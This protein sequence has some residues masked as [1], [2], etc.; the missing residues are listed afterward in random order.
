MDIPKFERTVR[1][2]TT[3][4]IGDGGWYFQ[5]RERINVGP[6]STRAH[7]EEVAEKFLGDSGGTDDRRSRSQDI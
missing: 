1:R 3:L 6:F 7:A 2:A 5:T 4:L